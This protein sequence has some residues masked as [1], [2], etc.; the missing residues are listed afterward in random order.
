MLLTL[1]GLGGWG[2]MGGEEVCWG[3]SAEEVIASV[4]ALRLLW[5]VGTRWRMRSGEEM[6]H[7]S[8]EQVRRRWSLLA[9]HSGW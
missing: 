7:R 3:K 4:I 6:G 1:A 5:W 2:R 8:G 9:I